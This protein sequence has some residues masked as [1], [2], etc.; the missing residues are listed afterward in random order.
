MEELQ[1]KIAQAMQSDF[2]G[3]VVFDDE[4]I[5]QMKA[6]CPQVLPRST[7]K[8]VKSLSFGRY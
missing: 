1:Q 4:E 6:D 8:L 7:T 3:D 2:V 5:E